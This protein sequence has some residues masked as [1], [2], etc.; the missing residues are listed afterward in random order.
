MKSFT[1]K[2]FKSIEKQIKKI[3]SAEKN[4]LIRT[5]LILTLLETK[6]KELKNFIVN[7]EFKNKEEEI[8]FFKNLKPQI[9]SK[10]I[11]YM[12]VYKIELNRPTGSRQTIEIYLV[13]ELDRLK[14]YFDRNIE[15]YHYYRTGCC[16]LDEL[17]FLRDH[18]SNIPMNIA[19][20]SFERDVRFSTGYDYKIAKI[21]AHDFLELYLKSE[22][23]KIEEGLERVLYS[24]DIYETWTASQ[25]DLG[26]LVYALFTSK[27]FNNGSISLKK[28]AT[29]LENVFNVKIGDIYHVFSEI[30]ERKGSRTRFL[31]RLRDDLLKRMDELDDSVTD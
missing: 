1:E 5:E 20:F 4:I 14:H 6:L 26:E 24:P 11:Y 12:S 15:L 13:T 3:E 18:D 30:R 9:L 27:C 7:Y 25:T 29:Y 23:L 28:L 8:L 22:L 21:I 17:Y 31:D 10:L 19:C 2:N 16:H